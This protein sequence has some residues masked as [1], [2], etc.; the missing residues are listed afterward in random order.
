MKHDLLEALI[1]LSGSKGITAKDL[2]EKFN[3]S[4]EDA[5]HKLEDFCYKY[6]FFYSHGL[7]IDNSNNV[8][9]MK[10]K[11]ELYGQ[12]SFFFDKKPKKLSQVC[13]EVLS[14]IAVHQ[15]VTYSSLNKLRGKDSF[16]PIHILLNNKLIYKLEKSSKSDKNRIYYKTTS[17]F[18]KKFN[19]SDVN[20]I[21]KMVDETKNNS[22]KKW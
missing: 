1:F 6:N 22:S 19:I 16:F 10:T 5:E 11:P 2:S 21:K 15:P 18:L 20:E 9:K 7:I 17:N 14:L 3:I 4:Y 12:L 13:L 8:Y